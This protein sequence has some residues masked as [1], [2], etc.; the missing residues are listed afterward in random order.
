MF[1]FGLCSGVVP[2]K[3]MFVLI[4]GGSFGVGFGGCFG[5]ALWSVEFSLKLSCHNRFSCHKAPSCRKRFCHTKKT[6]SQE[7]FLSQAG[8]LSQQAFLSQVKFLS[9][10]PWFLSKA[11]VLSQMVPVAR[12]CPVTRAP[13]SSSIR[14]EIEEIQ[15]FHNHI[16]F[17]VL[18]FPIGAALAPHQGGA[19][20]VWGEGS[21]DWKAKNSET[22]AV[23][24]FLDFGT[25]HLRRAR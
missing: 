1:V 11:V 3:G 24:E 8:F 9:P 25:E 20:W 16:S 4:G 21:T 18:G 6:L 22:S 13:S 12:D 14:G 23:P 5:V 7:A 2:L 15:Q 19:T 10:L 17:G